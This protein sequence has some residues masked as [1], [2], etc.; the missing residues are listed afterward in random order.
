[1]P[2]VI[3]PGGGTTSSE[4]EDA[5]RVEEVRSECEANECAAAVEEEV[6][7]ARGAGTLKCT[8]AAAVEEDAEVVD[9][10]GLIENGEE[11]CDVGATALRAR[12][13]S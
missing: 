13:V 12:G 6:A 11:S 3:V 10:G 2:T 8:G 5:T 9:I 4:D 1:M 7:M